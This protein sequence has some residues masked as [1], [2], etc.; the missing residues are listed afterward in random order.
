MTNKKTDKQEKG[1][2]LAGA[3]EKEKLVCQDVSCPTHGS[4]KVRGRIF[5]GGV[6]K[7]FP[8][9]ITIAFERMSYV[10]KYER[11]AR[12]RTKI[13][14]RVPLCMENEINVGDLV[15]VQECRPLSK[16]I[17]SVVIKKIKSSEELKK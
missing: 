1:K 16:I 14:S 2:K 11:Y 9:R 13:H 7:K 6:I 8:K 17:H 3:G 12:F 15:W 5:E 10:K 4:L